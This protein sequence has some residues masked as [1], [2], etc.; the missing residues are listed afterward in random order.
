M[1]GWNAAHV[2][3]PPCANAS[4]SILLK[5]RGSTF[6]P[7]YCA[8]EPLAC[9]PSGPCRSTLIHSFLTIPLSLCVRARDLPNALQQGMLFLTLSSLV[10][11]VALCLTPLAVLGA[12]LVLQ[13]PVLPPS[14]R[15]LSSPHRP[16]RTGGKCSAGAGVCVS[17]GGGG[18]V[19]GCTVG[20]WCS[21]PATT[22]VYQIIPFRRRSFGDVS[23]TSPI[24]LPLCEGALR[25]YLAQYPLS[26]GP[27]YNSTNMHQSTVDLQGS[28]AAKNIECQAHLKHIQIP[29]PVAAMASKHRGVDGPCTSK[30]SYLSTMGSINII[31]VKQTAGDADNA[32]CHHTSLAPVTWYRRVL[33]LSSSTNGSM[34][35]ETSFSLPLTIRRTIPHM[36]PALPIPLALPLPLSTPA[37]CPCHTPL[38]VSSLYTVHPSSGVVTSEQAQ[39][40]A[41]SAVPSAV[42]LPHSMATQPTVAKHCCLHAARVMV[43][44]MPPPL[45]MG[46][47]VL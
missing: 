47:S 26:V 46:W 41:Q 37:S 23:L 9:S 18:C 20:D 38:A 14:W 5:L 34:R 13:N 31:P 1:F 42:L 40:P 32:L 45:K 17:G 16:S 6:L 35:I 7:S 4:V 22:W 27:L 19:S 24:P 28:V 11:S 43:P 12:V 2:P 3:I 33:A 25:A 44:Q 8:A 39:A 15:L 29:L 36:T 10:H 30:G 21:V